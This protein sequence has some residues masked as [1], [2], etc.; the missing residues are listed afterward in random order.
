M[1]KSKA[2]RCLDLAISHFAVE[3][4]NRCHNMASVDASGV[5]RPRPG[6][7]FATCHNPRNCEFA[8]NVRKAAITHG[9]ITE[10]EFE[11]RVASTP[12]HA[13]PT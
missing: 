11:A 5:R 12:A 9:L 7:T 13:T 4:A 3:R 8:E 6:S 1:N 2:A 10:E